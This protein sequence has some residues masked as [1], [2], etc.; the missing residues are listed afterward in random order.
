MMNVEIQKIA[1]L[2]RVLGKVVARSFLAYLKAERE[3]RGGMKMRRVPYAVSIK[4]EKGPMYLGDFDTLTAYVVNLRTGEIE[5]EHYCGSFDSA[6]HHP[7]QG[8][9]L[10]N[11]PSG[12]A[13]FFLTVHGGGNSL[14]WK[15][16]VVSS[17]II[18]QIEA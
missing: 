14:S 10:T 12:Y 3:A 4:A 18:G 5:G 8:A 17:D 11:V 16:D 9:P 1:D 2:E 13:V 15:L 7:E 6:L